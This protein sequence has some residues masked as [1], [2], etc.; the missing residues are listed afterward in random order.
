MEDHLK[1]SNIIW[2]KKIYYKMEL[3]DYGIGIIGTGSYLPSKI[4]TNEEL[5]KTLPDEITPEWIIN[6]TGI[7]GWYMPLIVGWAS[8]WSIIRG[9]VM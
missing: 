8:I 9:A 2:L 4:E 6:K 7:K 1:K 5:C 3:C